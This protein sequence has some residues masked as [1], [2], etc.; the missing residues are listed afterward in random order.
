MSRPP[1]VISSEVVGVVETQ[2]GGR[3]TVARLAM[4]DASVLLALQCRE[5][6]GGPGVSIRLGMIVSK[7]IVEMGRAASSAAVVLAPVRLGRWA[8]AD[9]TAL[10]FVRFRDEISLRVQP[11]RE[12][13]RPVTLR[14]G[15]GAW[16]RFFELVATAAARSWSECLSG[17]EETN[18]D[19][20]AG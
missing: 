3:V 19:D 13:M 12:A 6:H 5:G 15:P 18:T 8:A 2:H 16:R 14:L 1:A 17:G 4:R 20:D 11:H 7:R 10:G 9:G